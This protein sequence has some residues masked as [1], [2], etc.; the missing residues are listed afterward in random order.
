LVVLT[1]ECGLAD[2]NIGLKFLGCAEKAFDSCLGNG[3]SRCGDKEVGAF[4][5]FDSKVPGGVEAGWMTQES[6]FL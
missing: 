3:V 2:N 6:G 4:D 1:A 5:L